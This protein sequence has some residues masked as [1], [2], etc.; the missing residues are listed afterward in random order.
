MPP[1]CS[2]S[3]A[4]TLTR[5]M[6]ED[7]LSTTGCPA[8]AGIASN[9]LLARLATAKAKPNGQLCVTLGKVGE[10]GREGG[11]GAVAGGQGKACCCS[12]FFVVNLSHSTYCG[13]TD[14][15]ICAECL[16]DPCALPHLRT[17]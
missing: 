11:G 13:I 9:V 1:G 7:I 15:V 4:D 16:M 8:S 2:L 3:Q 14:G 5:R 10:G 6:R 12:L 17:C